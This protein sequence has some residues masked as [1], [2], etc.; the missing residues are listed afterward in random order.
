MEHLYD[1]HQ[2]EDLDEIPS[3]PLNSAPSL[4]SD[5][6]PDVDLPVVFPKEFNR[7]HLQSLDWR[8][9]S[10]LLAILIGEIVIIISELRTHPPE[11][12]ESYVAKLQSKYAELFL[13]EFTVED[14]AD[15]S[16]Q[17]E[18]LLYATE[19]VP[20]I[21][22]ETLGTSERPALPDLSPGAGTPEARV[23]TREA[24]RTKQKISAAARDRARRLLSEHVSRIG[25]L[26]IIT[27][28]SSVVSY[29]PV[30]DILEYADSN[31]S[32]LER[33]LS[34]VE[35]LRVPRAGVDYYGP[36]V[37]TLGAGDPSNVNLAHRELVGKRGVTSGVNPEDIVTGLA[38]A[39]EK[40]VEANRE[41]EPVAAVPGLS[42]LRARRIDGRGTRDPQK[43]RE[44]VLS[45]NAAI[46]DCYRQ[47]L[48]HNP[49]LKGKVT[50]R[51]TISYTGHVVEVS[52]IS[53]TIALPSLH[54]CILNKI[55]RWNDFGAVDPAM[56]NV[57]IKQTYAFGY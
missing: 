8:F 44:I 7:S 28:G 11:L 26:G 54:I 37:G 34:R 6:S 23:A 12:D 46:Q 10:I 18:L 31:L 2:Y 3:Q 36:A 14:I 21:M 16:P 27:S 29:E 25:L 43:I 39:P 20:A 38:G 17:N 49:S 47:E 45:H 24:S 9:L 22:S 4:P 19:Y 41:Y 53:S 30:E 56:D 50:V 5:V 33:T 42:G 57:T 40:Q 32:N 55:S 35:T 13:S 15:S 48:K 51:F 52:V 1:R